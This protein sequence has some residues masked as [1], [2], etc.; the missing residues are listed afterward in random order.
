VESDID[1][2]RF[3]AISLNPVLI[4]IVIKLAENDWMMPLNRF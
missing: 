2:A 4:R 1:S 3:I